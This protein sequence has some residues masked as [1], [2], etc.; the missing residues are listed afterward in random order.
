VSGHSPVHT[1]RAAPRVTMAA[2]PS[3]GPQPDGYLDR[4]IPAPLV[5]VLP[6]PRQSR[7]PKSVT[8]LTSVAG[9]AVLCGASGMAR[10]GEPLGPAVAAGDVV[11]HQK[12][13]VAKPA[14]LPA[15]AEDGHRPAD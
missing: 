1:T 10:P 14:D 11:P 13:E 2:M 4:P 6:L 8:W 5:P 3:P 12:G 9:F 7:W 15:A